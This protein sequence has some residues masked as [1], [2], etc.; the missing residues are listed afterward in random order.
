MGTAM[1]IPLRKATAMT[2]TLAYIP[3]PSRPAMASMMTAIPASTR[4]MLQMLLPGTKTS[5][6]MVQE[7]PHPLSRRVHHLPDTWRTAQTHVR[8][9]IRTILMEMG[10]ATVPIRIKMEMAV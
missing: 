5:M 9:I 6:A 4:T 10:F 7:T 3:V 1:D 2:A 8:W